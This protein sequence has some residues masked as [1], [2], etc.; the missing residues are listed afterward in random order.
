MRKN[1]IVSLALITASLLPGI[2][3]GAD[4]CP[5]TKLALAETNGKEFEE[6][7]RFFLESPMKNYD[8]T[9]C[10]QAFRKIFDASDNLELKKETLFLICLS[11]FSSLQFKDAAKD[12][13]LLS[14]MLRKGNPDAPSTKIA[15]QMADWAKSGKAMDREQI[16]EIVAENSHFKV[17][18]PGDAKKQLMSFSEAGEIFTWL[19]LMSKAKD[20]KIY[21]VANSAIKAAKNRE[22]AAG[23]AQIISL[24]EKNLAQIQ[25]V[26]DKELVQIIGILA[27]EG[28]ILSGKFPA[29]KNMA[30]LSVCAFNMRKIGIA[31]HL[32]MLEHNGEIPTPFVTLKEKNENLSWVGRLFPYLGILRETDY[33]SGWQRDVKREK[34]PPYSPFLCPARAHHW[35]TSAAENSEYM[36]IG[37]RIGIDASHF[38]PARIQELRTEKQLLVYEGIFHPGG[39]EYPHAG[40]GNILF[41]DGHVTAIDPTWVAAETRKLKAVQE[42]CFDA[43]IKRR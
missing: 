11:E 40:C 6:V 35:I 23:Y 4:E 42:N 32:Y 22:E 33:L 39:F 15:A 10:R 3:L 41:A 13:S 26:S 19:D 25:S 5:K 14:E 30:E 36:M 20:L 27:L 2:R 43:K 16:E 1:V 29:L 21:D 9:S 38:F 31:L 18:L 8:Y 34:L 17:I 28:G 37:S 7:Y 12:T 24:S